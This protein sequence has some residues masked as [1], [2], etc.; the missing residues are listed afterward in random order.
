MADLDPWA[1]EGGFVL[2]ALP[3]FV[4]CDFSSFSTQNKGGGGELP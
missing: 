3:A 1:E 2:L 4:L